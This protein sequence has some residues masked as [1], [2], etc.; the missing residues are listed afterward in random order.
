MINKDEWK[1]VN[2][3]TLEKA[4]IDSIRC[5]NNVCVQA[6]PGAGKT[7]LLAQ[8]ANYLF[9]TGQLNNNKKILAISFKKD[10]AKNLKERVEKR[11][12]NNS[13]TFISLTYDAFF[14]SIYDQFMYGLLPKYVIPNYQIESS[15]DSIIS[16]FEELNYK[17]DY[18]GKNDIRQLYSNN[19]NK[20]ITQYDTLS[21]EL[22]EHKITNDIPMLSFQEITSI[23]YELLLNNPMITRAIQISY[24]YVFLDEFQ[25]T[26][27]IQYE[28]IKMIFCNSDSLLTA[29]GDINQR[30]MIWAGADKKVFDNFVND[31]QAQ[32]QILK[33]NHRSV[34]KLVAFQNEVYDVLS[35][36][37]Q[38]ECANTSNQE[39]SINLLEFEN[40]K[41]EAEKIHEIINMKISMGVKP[42]DI[43]ILVKQKVDVYC[44]D[45]IS[46]SN[47]KVKCRIENEYQDLIKEN[48]VCLIIAL[49]NV[50]FS[51]GNSD[52]WSTLSDFYYNSNQLN[53]FELIDN[54]LNEIKKHFNNS[55]DYKDMVY[56]MID[57]LGKDS[58]KSVY[59]EYQ[60]SHYLDKCIDNFIDKLVENKDEDDIIS[61]LNNFL[62]NNSIP[63]MTIHKSKGLE[64]N[65][66]FFVGLEDDAFWTFK[67]QPDEDKCAFF[68]AL[69]R[70]KESLF[71]T[72]NKSRLNKMQTHDQINEIYDLLLPYKEKNS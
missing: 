19:K 72:F 29:V 5:E 32:I 36:K 53:V 27:T 34:N 30:I 13:N 15:C 55:Q 39:G 54:K 48:I 38:V 12:N 35:E 50:T 18:K 64:Y 68:V 25:D 45:I 3:I 51:N 44:K 7:E 4:A 71:F 17:L 20:R 40:S 66:V 56:K 23:V 14:K 28:I 33:Q 52:S 1:P 49:I 69:S 43:C 59:P 60:Y 41:S 2:N 16:S 62:G 42:R 65:T 67:N 21:T 46:I 31:F 26:T 58:I 63:I 47:G 57:I 8:K 24:K 22:F 61:T 10:A 70:A 11:I 37:K 9:E 6:G